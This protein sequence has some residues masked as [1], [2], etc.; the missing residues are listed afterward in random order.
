MFKNIKELPIG[1]RDIIGEDCLK[2]E[3][4]LDSTNKIFNN[5]SYE[6]VIT[7]SIEF[8]DTFKGI[9]KAI[10]QDEMYKLSD[11]EGK[12]LS[13]KVDATLPIARVVSSK[14]KDK[15]LPI[16]IR[17][18]TNVFK[19]SKKLSGKRNESLEV[20][21]EL[22]SDE[23]FHSE[24]E[25]IL[26]AI[27]TIKGLEIKNFKIE[28]GHIGIVK[29][30]IKL[31]NLDIEKKDEFIEL[32]EE[33]RLIDLEEFLGELN[34]EDNL[35][36]FLK[37]FPWMFGDFSNLKNEKKYIKDIIIQE[38][39]DYIE[40]L[41][42]VFKELGLDKYLSYDLSVASKIDY[43]SGVVFK[44][45]LENQGNHVIQGGRYDSLMSLY[46]RDVSAIGFSL[47]IDDLLVNMESIEKEDAS[48]L[49]Y[50]DENYIAILKEAIKL[51]QEGKKIILVKEELS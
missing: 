41:Y 19:V 20:G 17:Y 12:L 25:A 3:K 6:E 38:Y 31:L 46:G 44:G 21:I 37:Q 42:G 28:I 18:S 33:K 4:I 48:K 7:P 9:S 15:K 30:V 1:M 27:E 47:N 39:V 45:Y 24:V 2:I 50:T 13:L 14:L 49:S 23:N 35:K 40:K 5:F 8:Y 32:V 10:N 26:I 22:I 11:R 36:I 16:R 51:N 43:Y 34:L 29:R